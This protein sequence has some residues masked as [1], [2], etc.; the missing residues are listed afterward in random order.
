MIYFVEAMEFGRIKIGYSSRVSNR[1]EALQK[2]SP[3]ELRQLLTIPGGPTEE[4]QLHRIFKSARAYG[5]WFTVTADLRAFIE[6]L[7]DAADPLSIVE[8]AFNALEPPK[9]KRAQTKNEKEAE[10]V[11]DLLMQ[12]EA[13]D[14][15]SKRDFAD[16]GEDLFSLRRRANAWASDR[17]KLEFCPPEKG[18][19]EL[20]AKLDAEQASIEDVLQRAAQIGVE[21]IARENDPA[22]RIEIMRK[23]E[24]SI[25]EARKALEESIAA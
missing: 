25:I 5:E 23:A 21:R 7:R 12:F 9:R 6:K 17:A 8:Q 14:D 4:A 13:H 22:Y 2:Q 18:A 16:A 24:A 3:T 10:Y 19:E 20:R 15:W 1:I 11:R